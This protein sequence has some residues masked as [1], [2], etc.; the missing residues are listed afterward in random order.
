MGPRL[1]FVSETATLAHF[2]RP[3]VLAGMLNPL[4][5]EIHFACERGYHRLIETRDWHLHAVTSID[6]KE[7]LSRM[8]AG[9]PLFDFE[10]LH[11]QVEEDLRLIERVQPDVI[12]GDLRH[13][14]AVSARVARVPYM[15]ISNAYWS[16]YAR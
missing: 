3:Q 2:G 5:Y 13:S 14:L 16:P 4:E 11:N 8:A 10:T 15:N 6:P 1:L 9:R 7:F 12:I